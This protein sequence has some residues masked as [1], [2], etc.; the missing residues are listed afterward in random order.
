[1]REREQGRVGKGGKK[2]GEGKRHTGTSFSPLRA[3]A[4]LKH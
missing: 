4:V 3:L 1:V 2:K